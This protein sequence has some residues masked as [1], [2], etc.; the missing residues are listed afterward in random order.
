MMYYILLLQLLCGWR[1]CAE[2]QIHS[3]K[4][5]Y[6]HGYI[7]HIHYD[8]FRGKTSVEEFERAYRDA[9]EQLK[10]ITRSDIRV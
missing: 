6:E 5:V 2:F 1:S 8:Y 10:N 4:D 3:K 9:L 7:D